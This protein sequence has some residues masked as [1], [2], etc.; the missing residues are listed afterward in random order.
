[1]NL[2]RKLFKY[3][4]RLKRPLILSL[5]LSLFSSAAI[6]AQAHFLSNIIDRVFLGGVALSIVMPALLLYLALAVTRAATFWGGRSAAAFIAA[7]VKNDIRSKLAA[8]LVL[9]GPGYVHTQQTGELKNTLTAGVDALDAYVSEY[10]PQL[11]LAV[12]IPLLILL[13]VFPVDL[14]SGFVFLITAPLIPIFMILIG[15]VA[16]S[17]TKKQW[18]LL[19]RMNAFF[20]DVL[21]GLTMLKILGRSREYAEKIKQVTLEFR[22]TTIKVL[23]VAFLS[24]LVLELLASISTAI[25]AVEIG[26]RLL[27]ARMSFEQA[28]FILILAPEFYQPLRQLGARF[29]AGME[30]FT[31]A[32]RIFEILDEKPGISVGR[33]KSS[34]DIKLVHFQNVCYSYPDSE[35]EALANLDLQIEQGQK[36]AIVGPSGAGKSTLI[37]LLLRFID[38]TFGRLSVNGQ[39]LQ[40]IDIDFWRRAVSWLPQ[41]PFI[42]HD[43]VLENVRL[44]KHDAR[45]A[46]IERALERA[47]AKEFVDE[48]PDGLDT[49]IGEH[50]A[51]LSG[52]Q[53]QRI[54]LARVFLKDAPLFI[55]DE[56]TAHL[57][58]KTETRVRSS[59]AEL[60]ADRTMIAIAH[61]LYTVQTADI[62]YVLNNGKLT[63]SGRHEELLTR[64][65]D[66]RRLVE[67]QEIQP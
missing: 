12:L 61:R 49:L 1:M 40:E 50:G 52:G 27:Y 54:A 30:G 28:L 8:H 57:D 44:A 4:L 26:L 2:D 47:Q 55:L 65:A 58:A 62:I 35:R 60:T 19:S 53:A 39:A 13:F 25:I 16:Q 42:F 21:Q 32:K 9:L 43:T 33:V 34:I 24:A 10:L 3:L 51:R 11:V 45:T 6:V 14:L 37:S 41:H 46:E 56:A 29:H 67:A 23:R 36:V 38:P 66:Y 59:L 18:T 63:G 22:H 7:R 5:I 64:N 15:D 31:A 48:L 20:L 17:L